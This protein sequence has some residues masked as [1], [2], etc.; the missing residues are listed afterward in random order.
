MCIC[1]YVYVCLCMCVCMCVCATD[2]GCEVVPRLPRK[3]TVD[4][5]LVCV[6]VCVCVCVCV[7]VGGCVCVG[8]CVC[9]CVWR[10]RRE[11]EAAAEEKPGIQNQKQEPHA[12]MWGII[13]KQN[14]TYKTQTGRNFA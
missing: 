8:V 7:C 1:V 3:T 10:R 11:E 9:W 4:V 13:K 2:G 5:R 12:K 14:R 6:Y